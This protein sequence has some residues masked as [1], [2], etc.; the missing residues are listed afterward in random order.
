MS[1]SKAEARKPVVF[2]SRSSARVSDGSA[3]ARCSRQMGRNRE[4]YSVSE[5]G[6]EPCTQGPGAHSHAEDR[7]LYVIEGTMSVLVGENGSRLP[8]ARLFLY[9]EAS[10]HDLKTGKCF[11]PGFSISSVPGPFEP[12]CQASLSGSR[13]TRRRTQHLNRYSPVAGLV[14]WLIPLC[15]PGTDMLG[16]AQTVVNC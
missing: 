8:R 4:R 6:L 16:S 9:L 14:R 12:E 15:S 10:Q 5:C 3:S 1:T 7:P 11:A 2:G 13:R